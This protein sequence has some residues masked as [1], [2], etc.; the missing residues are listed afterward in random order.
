MSTDLR[1]DFSRYERVDTATMD[2]VASPSPGVW[3]KRL[4]RSGPEEGGRVTSIVR[5]DPGAAFRPH[6]HPDGEEI[7]VLDGVF[8]DERGDH[9]AGTW[10]LNPE[11]FAHS[12]SSRGGCTIYVKLRQAPGKDRA[13]LCVQTRTAPFDEHHLGQV[14]MLHLLHQPP[15]PERV[16]L[17]RVHP[18]A[19]VPLVR[20]PGGAEFFVLEGT[21]DDEKGHHGTGTWLRYPPGSSHTPRTKTG[22]LLYV[23]KNHMGTRRT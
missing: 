20:L 23:K 3:R 15:H 14:G 16:Y 22:C 19:E 11:G 12:P 21:F 13:P 10:L 7:F 9:P 8:T 6:E 17:L 1:S 5:Y 2:W 4:E 18:G